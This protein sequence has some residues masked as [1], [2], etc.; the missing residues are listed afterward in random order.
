MHSALLFSRTIP[1]TY[2]LYVVNAG[3]LKLNNYPNQRLVKMNSPRK[4]PL[5][6]TMGWFWGPLPGPQTPRGFLLNSS[7]VILYYAGE[8]TQYRFSN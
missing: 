6:E 1:I 7:L 5:I 4:G 2:V 8:L 3:R